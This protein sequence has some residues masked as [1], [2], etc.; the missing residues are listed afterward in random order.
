M[1][2]HARWP[3]AI[4]ALMLAAGAP[5]PSQLAQTLYRRNSREWMKGGSAGSDATT[6]AAAVRWR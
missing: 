1:M 6:A 4:V 3:L 2:T 5:A